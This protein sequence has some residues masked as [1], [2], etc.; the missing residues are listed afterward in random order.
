MK[1]KVKFGKEKLEVEVADDATIADLKTALVA[2]TSIPASN[3]KL[4]VPGKSLGDDAATLSSVGIKDKGMVMVMGTTSEDASASA[5]LVDLPAVEAEAKKAA[6]KPL[7]EET[8]HGK[9]IAAGAP[10]GAD[11]VGN[12]DI[13]DIP[14]PIEEGTRAPYL[15]DLINSAKQRC[16]MRVMSKEQVLVIASAEDM[17]KIPFA[18]IKTITAEPITSHEGKYKGYDI[19]NISTGDAASGQ[20]YLYFYPTQFVRNL[21]QIIFGF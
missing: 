9:V 6:A 10:A 16:R 20:L 7:C 18:Q 15:K 8:A 5:K 2:S 17:H 12:A 21:K 13:G 11:H 3:Q 1:L 19:L 14:L 4:I